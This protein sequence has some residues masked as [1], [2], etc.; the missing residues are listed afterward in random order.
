MPSLDLSSSNIPNTRIV[1][2]HDLNNGDV[3]EEEHR[4]IDFF[5]NEICEKLLDFIASYDL[6]ADLRMI[7][8]LAEWKPNDAGFKR[9]CRRVTRMK[10]TNVECRNMAGVVVCG[11]KNVGPVATQREDILVRVEN[12]KALSRKNLGVI[13]NLARRELEVKTREG[14]LTW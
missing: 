12:G 10:E 1:N 4:N 6:L 7:L 8:L 14:Q 9:H 2:F 11:S 3:R 13:G 5:V